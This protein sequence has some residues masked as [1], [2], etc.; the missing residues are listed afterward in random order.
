MQKTL[1]MAVAMSTLSL[2]AIAGGTTTVKSTFPNV[3]PVEQVRPAVERING[4]DGV[5]PGDTRTAAPG[6]KLMEFT[7]STKTTTPLLEVVREVKLEAGDASLS[8]KAGARVAPAAK[9][10]DKEGRTFYLVKAAPESSSLFA[11]NRY[12]AITDTGAVLENALKATGD[13]YEMQEPVSITPGDMVITKS[14]TSGPALCGISTVFLG[15]ND[16]VAKYRVLRTDASGRIRGSRDLAYMNDLRLISMAG[17][18]LAIDKV[19]PNSVSVRIVG[20]TP[21]A[22][23]TAI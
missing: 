3:V 2:S 23:S 21:A 13:T 1:G 15:A 4:A 11:R 19:E 14:R 12:F 6:A 22:C 10:V 9:I 5:K 18:H 16:G 17:T 20:S 7:V 8:L